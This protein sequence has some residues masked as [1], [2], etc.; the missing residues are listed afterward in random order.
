MT[1]A[2]LILKTNAERLK[3]TIPTE[4][5]LNDQ[6][7]VIGRHSTSVPVDVPLSVLSGKNDIISRRHCEISRTLDGAYVIRDLGALNGMYLYFVRLKPFA[8]NC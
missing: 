2:R 5:V 1:R 6:K 4:I 8:D 7:I 3:G